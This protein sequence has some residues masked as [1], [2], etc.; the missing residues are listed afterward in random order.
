MPSWLTAAISLF[1]HF[2]PSG[3]QVATQTAIKDIP[4]AENVAA[5]VGVLLNDLHGAIVALKDKGATPA[6]AATKVSAV[7]KKT[8]QA[9]QSGAI[10]DQDGNYLPRK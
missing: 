3:A 5:E 8:T 9:V 7:L 4:V 10:I 6:Q 2:L 1:S